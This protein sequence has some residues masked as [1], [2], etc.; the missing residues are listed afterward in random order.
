MTKSP[1]VSVVIP[2][3]NEA[4]YIDRLLSALSRQKDVD[5]EVIV[6]DA[7]SRDGTKEIVDSFKGRLQISFYEA[8]PKGPA[9]GRN[10]GAG[11]ARGE[12]LLFFDADVDLD[13]ELFIRKLV[14]GALSRSWSTASG[15]LKVG[16]NSF[17]GKIGHNQGYLNFMAHTKHP[18]MQ[19]YCMLTKRRVLKDLGGF[20]ENIKYGEDNDYATRSAKYGFGFVKD[21][22]YI[23]DPRRYEQEGWKL[24]AKNMWHEIYR[25]THG[26]NFEKNKSAYEFGK[27]K[28]RAKD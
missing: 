3:Y 21:A 18:I 8:P 23:V 26:F 13:D 28:A 2:A 11:H 6:S 5:F 14:D 1:E 25:L 19:G 12:W 7:E 17:L 22:F 15:Q 24:L 27:H 20:N 10:Q 16:G 4:T 9:F